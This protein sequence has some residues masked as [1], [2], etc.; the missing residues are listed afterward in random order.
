MQQLHGKVF[1]RHLAWAPKPAVSIED[2]WSSLPLP[3]CFLKARQAE[4]LRRPRRNAKDHRSALR[5]GAVKPGGTNKPY[6]LTG[7]TPSSGVTHR[8]PGPALRERKYLVIQSLCFLGPQDL[9]SIP[10]CDGVGNLDGK[11][12]SK[13]SSKTQQLLTASKQA[14]QCALGSLVATSPHSPK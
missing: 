9:L 2:R 4:M 10:Y 13:P 14:P 7:G 8:S 6:Y 5:I 3:L 1:K 11:L 12:L